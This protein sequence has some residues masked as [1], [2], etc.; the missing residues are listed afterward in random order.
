MQGSEFES[1]IKR[2][3]VIISSCRFLTLTLSLSRSYNSG[4]FY[5]VARRLR[6]IIISPPLTNNLFSSRLYTVYTSN[7]RQQDS[8]TDSPTVRKT[9]SQLTVND[10][11]TFLCACSTNAGYVLASCRAQPKMRMCST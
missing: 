6:Y 11:E 4:A 8:L 9:D 1:N 5:A 10:E 2:H 7:W 3:L